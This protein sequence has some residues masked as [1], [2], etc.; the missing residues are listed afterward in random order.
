MQSVTRTTRLAA[1]AER[2]WE[3]ASTLAGVNHELRP[4][5]RMTAPPGL[6]DATLADLRPGAPAGRSWILLGG[7]LPVDF[8][9]LCLVEI[10]PPLRFLER[11]RM[12]SMSTWQ[13]ERTI[14]P[15]SAGACALTDTLTFVLRSPLAR[16][17]G[18]AA[19]ATRIVTYL[20]G[21]RHRRL[22]SAHGAVEEG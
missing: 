8:D 22:V 10:E 4:I 17:P 1:P 2:V 16:A 14:E 13:H 20:F 7:F 21:H 12:L 6:R 5:M 19:L 3:R 11:S 15:L 18:A 9:D